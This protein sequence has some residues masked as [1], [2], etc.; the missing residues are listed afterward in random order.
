[1]ISLLYK[2][3]LWI[4]LIS[5]WTVCF[6]Q[7]NPKTD[8]LYDILSSER[9]DTIRCRCY[10]ELS[11]YYVNHYHSDSAIIYAEKGI[12]LSKK[13]GLQPDIDL[14]RILIRAYNNQGEYKKSVSQTSH[15]IEIL[16]KS[17]KPS[18]KARLLNYTGWFNFRQGNFT[19]A[20]EDL[21]KAILLA[22][23]MDL[24]NVEAE[25]NLGLGR[26]YYNLRDYPQEEVY[27]ERYLEL[28]DLDK[29]LKSVFSI[30]SRL[31]DV[32][33]ENGKI[34][35]GIEIYFKLIEYAEKAGDSL[36]IA[37]T[38]NRASWAYYQLGRLDESLE[39]YLKDLDIS[40]KLG[41]KPLI[42]NCLGNIGNIYRDWNFFEKAI[43]YYTL[44]IEVSREIGDMYNLT[45]LYKDI[46]AM[47]ADMDRYQLAYDNF[48]LHSAYNDTLQ[49]ED[50]KRRILQAQTQ[51]EV[52]QNKKDLELMAVRLQQNKYLLYGLAGLSLMVVLIALLFIRTNRLRSRQRME[53]M[54]HK[55]STLTQ[56]NLRTQMNPHFI[57]NTLNSIQY[58]VFQNDRIASNNYMT[59]FAKLIRKTLE[60]SEHTSIPI[61]EEIDALELYLELESLRFKEKFDWKID[62]DEEIDTFMYKIPTMLIQPFVENG[63]CHG[64]MHKEGNGFIHIGMKLDKD[65]IRCTIEDNGVGRK[66][67]MEIKNDKSENHR[68]LGTS[69]T[70]SRLRLVNSLYGKNMKI[71]YTDLTG[72]DG[73]ASGTRVEISIP[74]IT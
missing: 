72:E 53:A 28:V 52:E 69:I 61:H 38:M 15:I 43:E 19:I 46:S 71:E 37:N 45:W 34:E 59:K 32:K 33:R 13:I 65:I 12:E 24:K 6:G 21:E 36:W 73:E 29:E 54:N 7:V 63:I 68:S 67:A 39:L 74:I 22:R 48:M 27:Y 1:M 26:V 70:E 58:Y 57:F 30:L 10:L 50:Y 66:K 4:L 62:I 64:L 42:A 25:A 3:L 44:S 14:Y 40:R 9:S 47:Y 5:T 49:S 11:R 2:K 31:G 55:I 56:K 20:I 18:D 8:S 60:N 41:R 17:D 16:E 51:Y 23:E 35:E